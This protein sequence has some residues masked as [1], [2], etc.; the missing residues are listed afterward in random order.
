MSIWPRGKTEQE[1][2][3]RSLEKQVSRLIH[4]RKSLVVHS[5][6]QPTRQEW[7]NAYRE[8]Y[9]GNPPIPPGMKLC[10][11][12]MRNGF[13][14]QY[15]TTFDR[16]NGTASSGEVY[17]SVRNQ[18]G[19]HIRF[20]GQMTVDGRI[21]PSSTNSPDIV[22]GSSLAG[23]KR[24]GLLMLE[25]FF[26]YKHRYADDG[27]RMWLDFGTT[28]VEPEMVSAGNNDISRLY[29]KGATG[30]L[31]AAQTFDN[32]F[33]QESTMLAAIAEGPDPVNG[34]TAFPATLCHM[35]IFNPFGF[36]NGTNEF[37]QDTNVV[38]MGTF[39]HFPNNYVLPGGVA[40]QGSIAHFMITA[41]HPMKLGKNWRI[42]FRKETGATRVTPISGDGW[43]YGY[44]NTVVK[45][46]TEFI[47][48]I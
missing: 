14:R 39:Y 44:Y 35:Q 38:G 41:L 11:Y 26:R 42:N 16:E 12:D 29:G 10:W 7:E 37:R 36:L 40:R 15:M 47:N 17:P 28:V 23:N 43:I 46:D 27:T 45:D 9:D 19:S 21:S 22:I 34:A 24:K 33:P 31:S 18:V 8:Q 2:Y 1:L 6:R 20:I 5:I 13:I 30:V 32:N 3:V 4:T 48:V 25:L